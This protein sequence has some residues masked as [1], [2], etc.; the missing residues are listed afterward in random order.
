MASFWAAVNPV[1]TA[2]PEPVRI[3]ALVSGVDRDTEVD[4]LWAI[5]WP[6]ASLT[7]LARVRLRNAKLRRRSLKPIEF[8]PPNVLGGRCLSGSVSRVSIRLAMLTLLAGASS[9]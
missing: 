2:P 6:L 1:S 8:A 7:I 4:Q 9:G 5:C 3:S